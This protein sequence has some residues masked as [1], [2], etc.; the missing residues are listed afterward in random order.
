MPVPG[1][2]GRVG[3][4]AWPGPTAYP[5]AAAGPDL[6]PRARPVSFL[7]ISARLPA[8]GPPRTH[9]W[10]LGAYLLVELVFLLASVAVGVLVVGDGPPQAWALAL[11]LGVPTA[12]RGR[13]WPS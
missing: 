4:G 11:A 1:A 7:G 13:H 9:R 10:G 3:P 6:A 2:G 8:A 12:A 5:A